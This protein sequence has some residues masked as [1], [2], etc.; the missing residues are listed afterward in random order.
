MDEKINRN[1]GEPLDRCT[2]CGDEVLRDEGACGRCGTSLPQREPVMAA[3]G[4][5]FP[6]APLEV[7]S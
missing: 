1:E 3:V 6:P 4:K 5:R 2:A 7:R